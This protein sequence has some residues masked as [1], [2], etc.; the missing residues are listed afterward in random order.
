MTYETNILKRG[1]ISLGDIDAVH[2]WTMT[3]TELAD[4][5]YYLDPS[6]C[7]IASVS[8]PD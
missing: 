4:E 6:T 3:V 1:H 8:Q 2:T 5:F 7:V